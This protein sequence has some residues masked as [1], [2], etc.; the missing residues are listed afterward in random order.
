MQL[1]CSVCEQ[2]KAIHYKHGTKCNDCHHEQQRHPPDA[3][4]ASLPPAA[5]SPPPPLFPRDSSSHSHL[6]IEQRWTIVALHRD[7]RD[8][9]YIAERIPCDVKSVR[10]WL[11]HY[12]Q[13][14]S[15][16]D[17]PRSGRPRMTDEALDTAIVG[18][19]YVENH[20]CTPRGLKRKYQFE[21]SAR[22]IDRRLQEANLF[23]RVARHKKRL[24]TEEKRKRLSFAEG[25]KGWSKE[26]WERTW[27]HNNGISVLDFPPYSPDLNPIENLWS[28]MARRVEVRPASTMEALQDVIAEEWA[29]TSLTFLGKLAH[30]MPERC[31]AV[32]DAKGDHTKY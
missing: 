25:Y 18:A 9:N 7:G 30:S 15:V 10:R 24:S 32:I 22:T 19:A 20:F 27:L 16:A 21:P 1:V 23:G 14:H 26:Q 11:Q 17:E 4:A 2:W 29:A 12:E 8:D 3:D 6:S 31:Q 5:P 13:H 28:D